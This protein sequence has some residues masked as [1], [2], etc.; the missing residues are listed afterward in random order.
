MTF[1]LA[2]DTFSRNIQMNIAFQIQYGI[3]YTIYWITHN[4]NGYVSGNANTTLLCVTGFGA[5]V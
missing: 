1:E 3:N 2:L 5:G 4:F